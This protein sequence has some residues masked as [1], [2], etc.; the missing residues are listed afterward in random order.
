MKFVSLSTLILILFVLIPFYS[1]A[2]WVQTNG[3]NGGQV[4]S[5]V[6]SGDNIFAATLTGVYMSNDNGMNWKIS[7]N[8][9]G[10]G[11]YFLALAVSTNKTGGQNIFAG[12]LLQYLFLSTDDGTSW[13]KLGLRWKQ[14]YS[15]AESGPNMLAGTDG[16]GITFL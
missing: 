11:G 15:L 13:I 7:L 2:Q 3:P 5:L 12:S 10:V 1:F 9:S 14:I 4:L 6:K 16:G 8:D